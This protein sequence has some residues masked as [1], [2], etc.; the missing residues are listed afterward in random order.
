MIWS[1]RHYTQSQYITYF[2]IAVSLNYF[3]HAVPDSETRIVSDAKSESFVEEFRN[4][5]IFVEMVSS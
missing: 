5:E 3:P 2:L 4:T 1:T